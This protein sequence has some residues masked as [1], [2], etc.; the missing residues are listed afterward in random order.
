MG[1]EV[2]RYY[3]WRSKDFSAY[4]DDRRGS[5]LLEALWY[6]SWI[7]GAKEA[8]AKRDLSGF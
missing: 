4:R 5:L 2:V 1:N 7:E 3:D 8:A 6:R